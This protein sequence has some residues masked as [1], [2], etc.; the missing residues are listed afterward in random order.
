MIVFFII[1]YKLDLSYSINLYKNSCKY[2]QLISW[3]I[4]DNFLLSVTFVKSYYKLNIVLK[5]FYMK[6]NLVQ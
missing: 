4:D 3:E 1:L 5:Y 2:I 6:T